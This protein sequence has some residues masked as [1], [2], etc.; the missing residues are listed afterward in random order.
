LLNE[1]LKF[2]DSE[3][4]IQFFESVIICQKNAV[5]IFMWDQCHPLKGRSR[6]KT[7]LPPK[8]YIRSSLVLSLSHQH[9]LVFASCSAPATSILLVLG[10]QMLIR[11]SHPSGSRLVG[12]GK[13]TP[14]QI[15]V[16]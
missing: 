10:Q 11:T 5:K 8:K 4:N 6:E 3:K 9:S 14:M 15:C 16:S 2:E 12:K 1:K 13:G 7:P